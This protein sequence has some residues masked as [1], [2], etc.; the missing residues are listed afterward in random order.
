MTKKIDYKAKLKKLEE[1]SNKAVKKIE[2]A[3]EEFSEVMKEV[4]QNWGGKRPATFGD[5]PTENIGF[6]MPS[7]M[8]NC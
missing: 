5:C 3:G 1:A 7:L 6:K 2:K 8:Q 4:K